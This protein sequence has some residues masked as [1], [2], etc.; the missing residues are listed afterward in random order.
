[1]L[2]YTFMNPQDF[3]ALLSAGTG[4]YTQNQMVNSGINN[5]MTQQALQ[6]VKAMQTPIVVG[7]MPAAP[8]SP[9]FDRLDQELKAA[10]AQFYVLVNNEQKGP[11]SLEQLKGLAIVDV[12]DENTQVW[13][14]GT[15]QWE[16]LKTCLA[17]LDVKL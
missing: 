11:L 4:F 14:Q 16:S 7:N 6:N 9:L 10:K 5:Q 15:P 2:E 12:I 1:M 3:D 8:T 13:R 17:N